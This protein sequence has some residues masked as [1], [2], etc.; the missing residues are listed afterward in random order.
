MSAVEEFFSAW[1]KSDAAERAS[2]LSAAVAP[3]VTYADPRTDAPVTGPEALSE[4]VG[5]FSQAAP[6]AEALVIKS[7]TIHGM[8]RVTVA[9]RMPNGMEQMGQYFV[10]PA[11]G[12]IQRMTGFVGTGAPE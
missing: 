12:P 5:M 7:D 8:A 11:D 9:F 2:I 3:D 10:E 4:Y 6:G 1:A